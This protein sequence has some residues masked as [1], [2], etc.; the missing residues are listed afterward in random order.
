MA[1]ANGPRNKLSLSQISGSSDGVAAGHSLTSYEVRPLELR[2]ER[3]RR[4]MFVPPVELDSGK[5]NAPTACACIKTRPND[6]FTSTVTRIQG[7]M[8][9]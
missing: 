9:H 4:R 1:L 6:Y 5:R 3:R 2:K 7:W 8:Q